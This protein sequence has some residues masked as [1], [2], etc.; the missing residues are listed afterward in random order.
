MRMILTVD[1]ARTRYAVG[2]ITG[3][4]ANLVRING[5]T[6]IGAAM[7]RLGFNANTHTDLRIT[8]LYNIHLTDIQVG[9][10]G[11]VQNQRFVKFFLFHD[12]PPY[13][14]F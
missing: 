7:R 6:I 3:I 9:D 8:T 2:A 12:Y 13:C 5:G 1:G 14:F 11:F 10:S 4:L